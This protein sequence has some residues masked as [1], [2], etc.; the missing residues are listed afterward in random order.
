M[1]HIIV[2]C[3][4]ILIST[5][6]YSQKRYFCQS[7]QITLKERTNNQE[8]GLADNYLLWTG[9]SLY[10]TF[11]NGS[12]SLHEKVMQIGNEWSKY[13]NIKFLERETG[14]SNIRIIFND[15]GLLATAVGII[16]NQIPQDEPTCYIDT[17]SFRTVSIFKSIVLHTFGHLIGLQH[18]NVVPLNGRKWNDSALHRYSKTHEWDESDLQRQIIEPYSTS[19]SNSLVADR[20]SVMYYTPEED[21]VNEKVSPLNDSLSIM[22]KTIAGLSY[23]YDRDENP[24]KPFFDVKRFI[25]LRIEKNENGISLYPVMEI[26]IKNAIKLQIGIFFLDENYNGIPAF[27]SFYSFDDSLASVKGILQVPDGSYRLN[28]RTNDIG[29][30]LP[31]SEIPRQY[32]GKLKA[33][34]KVLYREMYNFNNQKQFVSNPVEL[35]IP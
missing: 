6:S 14:Q 23:P 11:I 12:R 10:I 15:S 3:I 27:E 13:A 20:R 30:Y 5:A 34:F 4:L 29:L 24:T 8:A 1:K 35:M 16:N 32:R 33:V 31:Y 25:S 7:R 22:D 19:V 17:S 26:E 28:Y 2:C 9:S 21:W 18:E